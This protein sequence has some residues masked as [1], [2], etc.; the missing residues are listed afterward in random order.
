MYSK[1]YILHQ[2]FR[3]QRWSRAG[4][5]IFR[6]LS[7]CVTIGKLSSD[8]CEKAFCKL[9]GITRQLF[10]FALLENDTSEEENPDELI[11]QNQFELIIINYSPNTVVADFAVVAVVFIVLYLAVEIRIF[12]FQPFFY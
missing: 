5:A 11:K 9:K 4:Y 6:S 7:L 12:L 2:N 8:I 1:N 3:F 10:A